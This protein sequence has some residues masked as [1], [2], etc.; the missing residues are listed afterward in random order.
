MTNVNISDELNFSDV[1]RRVNCLTTCEIN[2]VTSKVYMNPGVF[3]LHKT[4]SSLHFDKPQKN[5]IHSFSKLHSVPMAYCGF[6]VKHQENI[7]GKIN[8]IPCLYIL[9][10]SRLFC[11]PVR[12]I[13]S[14][15]FS[16]FKPVQS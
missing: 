7:R 16:L 1:F 4:E 6:S 5:E 10:V 8:E 2:C 11:L 12:L 13:H 14:K 3:T 15:L 9:F